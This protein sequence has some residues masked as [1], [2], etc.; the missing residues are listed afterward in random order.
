MTVEGGL[1]EVALPTAVSVSA[2]SVSTMWPSFRIRILL[3]LDRLR[4]A[5]IILTPLTLF[6]EAEETAFRQA[7]LRR[8]WKLTT[9][10]RRRFSANLDAIAPEASVTLIQRQIDIFPSSSLE[11][12]AVANRRLVY[13]VDDA[14]WLDARGA[15][16]SL[17]AFLKASRHKARRLARTADHVIAGNAILAEYLAPLAKRITV[18]PSVVDTACSPVRNHVD[19][20][21][22]T[23]GWV[24]SRTTAPYVKRIQDLLRRLSEQLGPRRVRLLMVGGEIEPPDGVR[25]QPLPWSLENERWALERTDIGIMPQPD[26]PWTRGKCAYKAV[27]YM[28]A[29]IP[30]VADPVGITSGLIADGGITPGTEEEWFDALVELADDSGFR[31]RVGARGRRRAQDEY[32]ADR[33]APVLAQVLR[34]AS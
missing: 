24:G 23:I 2:V 18:I 15:N 12:R 20:D 6:S 28:A 8:K 31:A 30:V 9:D 13:D 32:S 16:G 22:L 21:E 5:G 17:L 10:A 27:Q 4:T 34:S 33:W 14:I 29:G 26:T 19:A 3:M 1:S 7:S 11:I 25:Y